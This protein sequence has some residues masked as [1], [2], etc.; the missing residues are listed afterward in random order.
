VSE[1]FLQHALGAIGTAL[2]VARAIPSTVQVIRTRRV[3]AG[4]VV[5]LD[6]LTVSGIWWVI[7]AVEIDNYPTL[8]SSLAGLLPAAATLLIL[9]R[10]GELHGRSVRL[11]VAGMAL[12]PIAIADS[13]LAAVTAA[14]LGALIAVPEAV[15]LVRDP[16]RA[17]EDI[18]FTM[19][20]LVAVNAVVW[21]AYGIMVE[22]P[23]LG[24]A[25]LVQ[26]PTAL[27]ICWRARRPAGVIQRGSPSAQLPD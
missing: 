23:V 20:L 5:G 2:Y 22:H 15:S 6:L 8:I 3:D 7:Y 17:D 24:L 12:I 26:L 1:E 19:W 25:G 16:E 9:R 10:A 21:L 11:L 18:S 27:V 13:R 14:V 4:G